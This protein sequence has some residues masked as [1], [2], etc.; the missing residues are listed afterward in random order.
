MLLCQCCC[1]PWGLGLFLERIAVTGLRNLDFLEIWPAPTINWITGLNGAGKT[2]I[3]EAIALLSRGRPFSGARKH[4]NVLGVGRDHLEI[5]AVLRPNGQDSSPA[6]SLKFTQSRTGSSFFEDGRAVGSVHQLRRRLHIRM[7]SGN[8]Q[9]LLDGPPQIR[10]LFL[11]W[12]LFHVEP[13]FGALLADLKKVAAQR[14]AWLRSGAVGPPAWDREYCSLS[15]MVSLRR[16]RMVAM[17][18][19]F[20]ANEAR[21]YGLDNS[22]GL[23]LAYRE[24]WPAN[25]AS[26]EEL[27]LDSVREDCDRG[28]TFYGPSRA[29]LLIN[30]SSRSI[31]PSRGESKF[32]VFLMQLAAQNYWAL[33]HG[34]EAVWLLDDLGAELD[35][36]AIRKI[37]HALTRLSVQVFITA[38]ADRGLPPIGY[39][40]EPLFHVEQGK[41]VGQGLH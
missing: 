33:H 25:L 41:L 24:G 23:G 30:F 32:I 29:E 13:G 10:R 39:Q 34:P 3:L 20:I 8:A 38:I 21:A 31:R 19:D 28:Y 6:S 18:N 15:E 36:R 27:L 26:L 11:D 1:E 22:P 17:M 16:A 35:F 2:S 12:N 40:D 9:Q 4:G 5:S 37:L 14:N 7:I